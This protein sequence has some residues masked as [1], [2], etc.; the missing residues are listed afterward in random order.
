MILDCVNRGSVSAVS[1]MM[2]M[3]DSERAGEIAVE[4]GIDAG[5]HL[6]FTERF[7]SQGVPAEVARRQER[8]IRYLRGHRLAQTVFHPG[9]ARSFAY[10]VAAQIDEYRRV[11]GVAPSRF[12]GHHHMHLC[13]NIL[14]QGLVPRGGLVR[15]TFSSQPGETGILKKAYRRLVDTQLERRHRTTDFLF[16]ILPMLPASRLSRILA[17]ARHHVVELETHPVNP[18]EHDFLDGGELFRQ[19]PEDVRISSPSTIDW[20]ARAGARR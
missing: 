11:Y 4:H 8:L 18:D 7:T 3:S 15:R 17:L 12:D 5:L 13:A 20:P 19:L 1:A 9:L 6:N 16:S 14:L 2:F 10:V